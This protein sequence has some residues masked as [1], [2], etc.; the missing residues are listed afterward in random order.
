MLLRNR[1]LPGAGI[2]CVTETPILL[3]ASVPSPAPGSGLPLLFQPMES[4]G[5]GRLPACEGRC[6]AASYFF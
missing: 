1:C 6:L 5:S 3:V 2:S 4:V